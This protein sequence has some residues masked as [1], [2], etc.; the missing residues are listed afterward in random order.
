MTTP[1]P[2]VWLDGQ[3]LPAEQARVSVY[4]RAFRSGEGV[5]ETL[6]VDDGHAFRLDQHVER[7]RRGAA[8]LGL[9][10]DVS[11]LRQAV[12][13]VAAANRRQRPGTDG[14]VRLTISAGEMDPA[15]PVP[16][17]P[18]GTPTIVATWHPLAHAAGTLPP[19]VT[20]VTVPGA[21]PHPHIKSVSSLP[22]LLA[23]REARERGADQALWVGD[24]DHVLE[25]ATA[26]IVAVV[27]GQL[28]SPPADLGL[29]PG[30]TL[31]VVLELAPSL[32][33]TVE[34]RALARPVLLEADEAM[35]TSAGRGVV[36][37]VAVDDVP[38]GDGTPGPIW[39]RL[40]DAY[41]AEA[42]RERGAAQDRPAAG[43]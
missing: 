40:H 9:T 35:L 39:R 10:I 15:L 27:D 11:T 13:E 37:L 31:D 6:R 16:G 32:G 30:V 12:A 22:A 24:D 23:V 7:A 25:A 42:A 2:L 33:L 20:A 3:V 1:S 28:W 18:I 14:V 21:R 19:P 26:N 41:R 17:T 36:P 34:R 29:L 8:A 5:Y 38:I 43:D 4:D